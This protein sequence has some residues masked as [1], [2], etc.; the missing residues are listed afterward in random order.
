MLISADREIDFHSAMAM[1]SRAVIISDV[2]QPDNPIVFANQAFVALTGYEQAESLGRNCRFL[3]GPDTDWQVVDEIREA[4]SSGLSIRRELLNYRKNGERFWNDVTIDPIRDDAGAVVGF[5]GVQQDS[6]SRHAALEAKIE[7]EQRL[8]DITSHV[9]GY[10]YR[11][12]LKSDGSVELPYLSPSFHAMLGLPEGDIVT[13]DEFFRRV[14]PDDLEG[15]KDGIM[16]SAADLSAFHEE[17]RLVSLNGR[18]HWV[19]SDAPA[20]RFPNGDVVWDGLAL[21]ITR[22]KVTQDDLAFLAFHDSLTGLSNRVRFKNALSD[23]VAA[24]LEEQQIGIFLIDVDGFQE[25]NEA[26]GQPTGDEVLRTIGQ[27]LKSLVESDNGTVARL[28]GDEFAV[29]LPAMSAFGS[30]SGFAAAISHDVTRPMQI[31]G[32]QM[33]VQ[34]CVGATMFPFPNE[35]SQ[36]IAGD[37]P[38]ELMKRADLALHL[39]KQNGPGA[40]RLYEAEFDDRIRNRVALRQSL[41]HAIE[42][43]QFELHYHPLVEL[44]SGRIVG[45]EALVRWNHPEFGMQRPDLFIPLA[46]TSGL[47]VPLGAWVMTQAM[48]QHE[49]WR[50]Q[51]LKPPRISIN[52]SSVQ[53]KKADFL[54]VVERALADTR[55]DPSGFDL[56]LTEGLLIEPSPEILDVLRWLKSLGFE[57]TVDDFGTGHSTFKYL[58]EFPVDKIKIDQTFVRQLVVESS[59][60]AIVRAMIGLSRSLGIK[61]VAEGIETETQRD[62]LLDEGC[63]IGQ[64]YLFSLPLNAEDFGWL[65]QRNMTLPISV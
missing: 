32:R 63:E 30:V 58:R 51:G 50:R 6:T 25:I 26:F 36:L 33:F 4:I 65:I 54:A 37:V 45:A 39:A 31:L 2:T 16:R 62:F 60:A 34:V 21:E 3:Q 15:L 11:R 64:G 5:I 20:R 17:F 28:G 12:V 55:A 7:A 43:Q 14:H 41:H 19:R 44:A 61:I 35:T 38:T 48:R 23:A 18:V 59:D 47:I 57:I 8:N 42:D 29:L 1:T 53:L 52:L 49:A 10:V 40:Q 24:I 46:E 9:P 27:R 56:E 13:A 22:E